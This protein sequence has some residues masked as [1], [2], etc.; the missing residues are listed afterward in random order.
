MF[1]TLREIV[2]HFRRQDFS[3][4]LMRHTVNV[5]AGDISLY[6]IVFENRCALGEEYNLV[7]AAHG[8][9]RKGPS[10]ILNKI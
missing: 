8:V 9:W 1:L 10:R 2:F 5:Q 4:Y 7:F 6:P 3:F